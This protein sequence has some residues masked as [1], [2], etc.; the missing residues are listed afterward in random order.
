MVQGSSRRWYWGEMFTPWNRAPSG[1]FHWGTF[2]FY[3]SLVLVPL[4][5]LNVY[6][7]KS[8][9]YSFGALPNEILMPFHR[10][11]PI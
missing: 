2:F 1:K 11:L 10:V 3:I 5:P 9:G 4:A 6:P 8:G 7:I